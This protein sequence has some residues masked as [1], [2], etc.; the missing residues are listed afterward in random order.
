MEV[1]K[2]NINILKD[3]QQLI[4][5]FL[6]N[7]SDNQI[8]F[9][10]IKDFIEKAKIQE[11]QYK[12]SFLLHMI[13][14]ISNNH[15]R[16]TNFFEKIFSILDYLSL[17]IKKYFSSSELFDIFE[18][19][20]K[21]LL[22]LVKKELIIIDTSIIK[23]MSKGKYFYRG[24]LYYFS[25]E[26]KQVTSDQSMEDLPDDFEEKRE[27]G[28]NDSYICQLI[29]NDNIKEFISYH[30]K[31]NCCFYESLPKSKYETNTFLIDYTNYIEYAAFFGSIDIFNYIV[32]QNVYLPPSLWL[33][34]IHSQN[35]DLI[36]KLEELGVIP[37]DET[38]NEC[39]I[40]SIKCHHNYI[41]NY[42]LQN[43]IQ[44]D[45]LIF[46]KNEQFIKYFNFSFFEKNIFNYSNIGLFIK[47][48]YLIVV[49]LLLE[50]IDI[51]V[52]SEIINNQK[53]ILITFAYFIV[54]CHFRKI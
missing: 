53:I 36:H 35:S 41:A 27:I 21:T 49:Q 16:S 3:L 2:A 12:L 6:D 32:N 34:A 23:K 42:F 14:I 18:D 43:Y 31:T 1:D 26:I 44:E 54:S 24:Y 45:E 48:D 11:D 38:Y 52:N 19:N 50:Y 47:Y 10:E 28:E 29:R 8:N 5:E 22:F 15:H 4:I 17:S 51:D 33:F 20:K 13:S 39:F 40:E 25:P 46:F 30:I 9:H 37:S 7:D